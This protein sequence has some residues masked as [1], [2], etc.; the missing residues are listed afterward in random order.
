MKYLK[1]SEVYQDDFLDLFK[2]NKKEVSDIQLENGDAFI[3]VEKIINICGVEIERQLSILGSDSCLQKDGEPSRIVVN[4]VE[5]KVRQRFTL[6]HE[7]GHLILGHK[8][9]SFRRM[10]SGEYKET[11]E[12]MKEVAANKFAANLV[13]PEKLVISVLRES[14]KELKLSEEYNFNDYEINKLID[15]SAEKMKVS[16]LVFEYRLKNMGVLKNV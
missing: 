9:E 6:A 5:S 10:Y 7:L 16:S 15:R 4:K 13:M 3:D 1:Y 11:F 8:G 12:R 2:D 14:I